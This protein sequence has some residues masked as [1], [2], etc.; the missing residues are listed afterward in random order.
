MSLCSAVSNDV[1]AEFD[2]FSPCSLKILFQEAGPMSKICDITDILRANPAPV[3]YIHD[4]SV[5]TPCVQ[6]LD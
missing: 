3:F 4:C 1:C 5:E 6:W 2:T